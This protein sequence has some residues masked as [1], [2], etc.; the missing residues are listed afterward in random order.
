MTL[1]HLRTHSHCWECGYYPEQSTKLEVRKKL[2]AEHFSGK[3][4]QENERN[5]RELFEDKKS[6][7]HLGEHE[8]E[9]YFKD[10]ECN[11][12]EEDAS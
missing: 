1:E 6:E 10:L 2:E 11:H 4:F 8:L 3:N 7:S 9:R 5:Y 12:E